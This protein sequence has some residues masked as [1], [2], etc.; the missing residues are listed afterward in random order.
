[1]TSP[2]NLGAQVGADRA[3]LAVALGMCLLAARAY[4]RVIVDGAFN[5]FRDVAGLAVECAQGWN[6]GFAGKTLIQPDQIATAN[7]AFAPFEAELQLAR[8]QIAA[9]EAAVVAGQGVAVLDG[10]IVENL[11]SVSAHALIAKA[12]IIVGL[13]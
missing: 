9:F 2:K 7:R 6:L 8:R 3:A 11:H 10:K 12:R 1:M 4:G 5:A 13:G